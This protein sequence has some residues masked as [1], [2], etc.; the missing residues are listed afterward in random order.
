MYYFCQTTALHNGRRQWQSSRSGLGLSEP[1]RHGADRIVGAARTTKNE[2]RA[3]PDRGSGHCLCLARGRGHTEPMAIYSINKAAG[4][5]VCG[6]YQGYAVVEV[7]KTTNYQGGLYMPGGIPVQG[8]RGVS[9]DGELG[10][11]VSGYRA[12]ARN[13]RTLG[14]GPANS[15][16]Q[17][18][19][20]RKKRPNSR[21]GGQIANIA[22]IAQTS[23]KSP[24]AVAKLLCRSHYRGL[25]L[26]GSCESFLCDAA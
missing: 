2:C 9:L 1:G 16:K 13:V 21:N 12:R 24:I 10:D 15:Q 26:Y 8:R 3:L 11:A 18:A 23:A 20:G 14:M 19:D 6:R 7:Q 25:R 5:E 22:D 4:A 17:S